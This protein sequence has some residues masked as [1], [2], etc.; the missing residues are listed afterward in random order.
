VKFEIIDE[1]Q[2]IEIIAI[3]FGIRNLDQP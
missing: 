1:I 2:E 3:G